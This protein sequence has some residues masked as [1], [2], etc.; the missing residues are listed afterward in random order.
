MEPRPCPCRD[1]EGFAL[2]WEKNQM[3]H[4]SEMTPVEMAKTQETRWDFL[5]GLTGTKKMLCK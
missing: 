4:W 2:V 5:T 1:L 3:A